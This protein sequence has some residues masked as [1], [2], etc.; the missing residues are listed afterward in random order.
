MVLSLLPVLHAEHLLHHAEH[1]LHHAEFLYHAEA[2][3]YLLLLGEAVFQ[4]LQEEVGCQS[5]Q[6]EAVCCLSSSLSCMVFDTSVDLRGA[7]GGG[8]LIAT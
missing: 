2:V 5:L 1:L 7:T 4:S 8:K 6:E 3:R